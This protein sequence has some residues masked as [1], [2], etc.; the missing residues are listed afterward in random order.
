MVELKIMK[1]LRKCLKCKDCV[2]VIIKKGIDNSKYHKTTCS[3][4]KPNQIRMSKTDPS[5]LAGKSKAKY[6]CI[7]ESEYVKKIKNERPCSTCKP[8]MIDCD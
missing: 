4:F 7:K 2:I 1:D 6:Y 5:N 8:Q 3:I